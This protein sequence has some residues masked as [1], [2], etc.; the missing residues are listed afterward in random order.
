MR[1]RKGRGSLHG[2]LK[3]KNLACQCRK[4]D[5]NFGFGHPI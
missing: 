5:N 2:E 1:A 3:S 4:D